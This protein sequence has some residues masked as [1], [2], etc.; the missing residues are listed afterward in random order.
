MRATVTA[1]MSAPSADAHQRGCRSE[2]KSP[3]RCPRPTIAMSQM[4][5]DLLGALAQLDVVARDLADQ[6]VAVGHLEDRL[7]RPL[8]RLDGTAVVRPAA[9]HRVA[10]VLQR[11]VEDG[12]DEVLPAQKCR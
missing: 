8:E 1:W 3:E 5:A 7:H 11:L 4:R 6:A 10:R 2:R 12:A 9:D